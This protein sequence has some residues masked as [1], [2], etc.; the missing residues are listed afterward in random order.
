MAYGEY[1]SSAVLPTSE[2]KQEGNLMACA[3]DKQSISAFT[4]Q[5]PVPC[6]PP[7]P[8]QHHTKTCRYIHDFSLFMTFSTKLF[9]E[10]ASSN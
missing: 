8:P 4:N 7:P 9:L 3:I 5:L 10:R 2:S 6:P 1:I